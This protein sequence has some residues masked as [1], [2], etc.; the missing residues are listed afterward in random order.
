ML[1]RDSED[2]FAHTIFCDDIRE[3]I[4]GKATYVGVYRSGRLFVHTGFPVAL[5]KFGFAVTYGQKRNSFVQPKALRVFLPGDKDDEPSIEAEFPLMDENAT[6]SKLPEGADATFIVGM[7]HLLF[8]PLLIKQPGKIQ[9]R[10]VRGDEMIR[11]GS[12]EVHLAP[13][14]KPSDPTA[15]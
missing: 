10:A 5:P 7:A 15:S 14:A 13:E 12:L 1:T 11:L 2:Y 8:A 9:V 4:G 3:E 6:L